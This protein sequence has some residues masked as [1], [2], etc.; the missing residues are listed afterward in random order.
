LHTVQQLLNVTRLLQLVTQHALRLILHSRTQSRQQ[1]HLLKSRPHVPHIRPR[2]Q[3]FQQY[4][5]SQL[6]QLSQQ[7]KA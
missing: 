2:S 5:Q 3:L 4:L 6:S 1:R 7:S